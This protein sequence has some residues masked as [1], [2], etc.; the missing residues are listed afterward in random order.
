MT[1]DKELKSIIGR[2]TQNENDKLKKFN[3]KITDIRFSLMSVL[4]ERLIFIRQICHDR[5]VASFYIKSLFSENSEP[6]IEIVKTN[7]FRRAQAGCGANKEM[8]Y[9]CA[10]IKFGEWRMECGW[11]KG[12]PMK[13]EAEE[14]K[15][16]V[17]YRCKICNR[18]IGEKVP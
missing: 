7:S 8:A 18:I 6:F 14:G 13:F 15:S 9:L 1:I 12:R 17:I 11:V 3:G 2:L 4:S 16:G 5:G 10:K